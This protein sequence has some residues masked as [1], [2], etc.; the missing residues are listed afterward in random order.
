MKID[1]FYLK[2]FTQL[3]LEEKEAVLFWRNN[4]NVKK[5]MYTNKDISLEQHLNFIESLKSNPSKKYFLVLEGDKKIG[6][7]DFINITQDSLDMGLYTN[8]YLKGYGKIL[9]EL[10]VKHSFDVLSVKSIFAEVFKD[11]SKAFK[12]YKEFGFKIID[13]KIENQKEVYC[14]EL[15]YDNKKESACVK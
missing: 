14:M 10:I 1:N 2:D 8:P 6:V 9:L 3:S 11:N 13:T 12:L 5:W 15:K 7:I 4:E